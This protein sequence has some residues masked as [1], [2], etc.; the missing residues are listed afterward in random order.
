MVE[1]PSLLWQLEEIAERA[2]FLSVGSNDL[3]QYLYAADRDNRRVAARFDTL[4]AGFLRALAAIAE[5]GGRAGKPVTLCGEIGGRTLEAMTLIALG[6]RGLSMSAT[7]IG[8]VKAMVLSLDV[9]EASSRTAELLARSGDAPTLRGP[10]TALA[11]Q[12]GVRL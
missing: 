12:L 8:P 6:Y 7:S 5:A 9:A 10:L 1:V 11:E 2:D 3:L 4:S